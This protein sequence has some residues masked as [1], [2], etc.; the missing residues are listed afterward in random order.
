MTALETFSSML[1]NAAEPARIRSVSKYSMTGVLESASSVES[2]LVTK[3]GPIVFPSL[4]F[5]QAG[6]K[7]QTWFH[8]GRY[9]LLYKQ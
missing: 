7:C 9:H 5:S 4:T 8:C 3:L 2:K 6:F 1:K